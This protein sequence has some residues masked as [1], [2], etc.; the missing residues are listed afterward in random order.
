VNVNYRLSTLG[1]LAIP[2]TAIKGNFGIGDQINALKWTVANI[3]KFGGDPRQITII[4]ES[5]GAGS[6][7]ALLGSPPA[8]PLFQG[9][10]AMSYVSPWPC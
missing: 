3:A 8:I 4:G 7:R 9:A 1:F 2:G 10:V 6:V 5:A